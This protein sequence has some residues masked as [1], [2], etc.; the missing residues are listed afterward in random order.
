MM[1]YSCF[2][3]SLSLSHTH[4]THT[5]THTLTQSN[6]NNYFQESGFTPHPKRTSSQ[7]I[8][9]MWLV[10]CSSY[11]WQSCS[12]LG[13]TTHLILLPQ[14]FCFCFLNLQESSSF[15]G[16]FCPYILKRCTDT[17]IRFYTHAKKKS[18]CGA[19]CMWTEQSMLLDKVYFTTF[20]YKELYLT[21][22]YSFGYYLKPLYQIKQ[23]LV[24]SRMLDL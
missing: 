3:H 1:M 7:W 5:H 19:T 17:D 11:Q 22:Y 21:F 18:Y 15:C 6:L 24:K 2:T 16:F 14:F 12:S 4:T 9:C 10:W 13:P 23:E 8:R 20:L